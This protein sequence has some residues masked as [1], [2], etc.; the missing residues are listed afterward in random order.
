MRSMFLALVITAM[1][2]FSPQYQNGEIKCTAA[3]TQSCPDGYY[4]AVDRMFKCLGRSEPF[5]SRIV[6]SNHHY[7]DIR[8]QWE[9]NR[10]YAFVN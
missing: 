8:S 7:L 3:V 9:L 4:C 2:C 6:L 5:L 1:G 10:G